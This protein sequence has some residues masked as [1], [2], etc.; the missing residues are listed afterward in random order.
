MNDLGKTLIK[1]NDLGKTLHLELILVL[2][3]QVVTEVWQ[4]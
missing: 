4:N 1:M 3:P 2:E